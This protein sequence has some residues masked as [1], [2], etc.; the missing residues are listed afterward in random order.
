MVPIKRFL[1]CFVVVFNLVSDTC[2]NGEKVLKICGL[3]SQ[4]YLVSV[5]YFVIL[6]KWLD[7]VEFQFP[8]LKQG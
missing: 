4:K 2:R 1:F 6:S 7:L 8:S 3:W 5:T